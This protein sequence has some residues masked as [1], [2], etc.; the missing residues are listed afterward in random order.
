VEVNSSLKKHKKELIIYLSEQSIIS[1]I[2]FIILFFNHLCFLEKQID[3]NIK[4]YNE[5]N[6]EKICKM[7]ECKG[8]VYRN[9]LFNYNNSLEINNNIDILNFKWFYYING[10][11]SIYNYKSDSYYLLS[12]KLILK[13]LFLI[14]FFLLVSIILY[15]F[16][17][18][19]T[20]K[21]EKQDSILELAGTEAML[22][23][24][25]M[26]SITENIH[27]EL[28]TPL[29]VIDNKIDKISHIIYRIIFDDEI[30]L[31]TIK[32][33][34]KKRLE[35]SK[36]LSNLKDD[37]NFIKLA[38]EQIYT[39]LEKMR[40]FKHLKYSNG[41]KSILNIIEGGFSIMKMSNSNFTYYI[42]DELNNLTLRKDN[43]LNA[44]LLSILINHFKNSLEAFASK[45]Y[46]LFVKLEKNRLYFRIIDN[47]RGI[48]E[49][50]KKRI[51]EPNFSTKK[52][53]N[54]VRGNGMYLNK[55][56]IESSGGKIQLIE[57]SKKGTTIEI[58]INIK[59]KN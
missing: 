53:M 23:N 17:M 41:N 58:Q 8:I 40:S 5:I 34:T 11:I 15:F 33:P 37:F 24:K 44:D 51:F 52:D 48:P 7:I 38:S 25:T 13:Y 46:I 1:T 56:I 43:L 12:Y 9:I 22:T 42:S 21:K 45:I 26:I 49:N 28:N 10:K 57:S 32:N 47:G 39:V 50:A 59:Y 29:E 55:H 35:K 31:R 3:I 54:S 18:S 30:Q 27:H 14:L 36:K 16:S 2:I 6:R 4:S 19:N 20:L